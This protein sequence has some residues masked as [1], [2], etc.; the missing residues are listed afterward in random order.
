MSATE[1]AI[2]V[3]VSLSLLLLKKTYLS[4][5]HRAVVK[6]KRYA[7]LDNNSVVVTKRENCQALGRFQSR[8]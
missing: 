1:R 3:L 5:S 4:R 7:I 6:I 2:N 8:V